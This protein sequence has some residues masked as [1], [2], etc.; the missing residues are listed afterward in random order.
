MSKALESLSHKTENL[1]VSKKL[2]N[3]ILAQE[4]EDEFDS[5]Y[6]S[7][8]EM[9]EN[10]GNEHV[11]AKEWQAPQCECH[12]LVKYGKEGIWT[13]WRPVNGFIECSNKV[14]GDP[15]KG[16]VKECVCREG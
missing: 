13:E 9:D 16:K 3:R 8:T 2:K 10:S 15:W 5:D 7:D 4:N 11:C 14:F 6:D 1:K 12:G